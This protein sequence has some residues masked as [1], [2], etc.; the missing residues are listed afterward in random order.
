M[1]FLP[2]GIYTGFLNFDVYKQSK[3]NEVP[4]IW[5]DEDGMMGSDGGGGTS[6]DTNCSDVWLGFLGHV[7]GFHDVGNG[8]RGSAPKNQKSNHKKVSCPKICQVL[9]Q[10]PYIS[11]VFFDFFPSLQPLH[12]VFPPQAPWSR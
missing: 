5:W 2:K 11:Y 8:A 3:S 7:F 9:V 10:A 4:W 1:F 12:M 6:Q